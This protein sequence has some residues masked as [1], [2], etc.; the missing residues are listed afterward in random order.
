MGAGS[1]AMKC[2]YC[3][4]EKL[5]VLE[6]RA[7]KEGDG[8]RRRRV[9]ENCGQRFSTVETPEKPRVLVAKKQTGWWEDFEPEKLANSMSIA[10]RKRNVTPE[11]LLTAAKQI[12]RDLL[13]QG[14]T[15]V[16]S[17]ELGERAMAALWRLDKVAFI[18]FASVYAEFDNPDEFLKLVDEVNRLQ[19][20]TD[21][22]PPLVGRHSSTK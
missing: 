20:L 15:E 8:I 5:R 1:L 22:P 9:C 4:S 18:R 17:N 14:I 6:S 21:A 10:C 19:T 7:S 12:E 16:T 2:I 11:D 3:G 13:D